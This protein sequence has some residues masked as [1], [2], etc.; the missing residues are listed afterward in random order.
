MLTY[1][2]VLFSII[3][4]YEDGRLLHSVMKVLLVHKTML[5]YRSTHQNRRFLSTG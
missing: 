1:N 5:V 3:V 2:N 4:G